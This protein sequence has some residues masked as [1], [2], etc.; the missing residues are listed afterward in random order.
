M[1]KRKLRQKRAATDV[2]GFIQDLKFLDRKLLLLFIALLLLS[3]VAAQTYALRGSVFGST[4]NIFEKP[5][6]LSSPVALSQPALYP[7][8][9]T[10]EPPPSV[11]AQSA[12]VIDVPSQV[13]L[14]EK[15]QDVR[16]PA[17]STTKIM[18]A[19]VGTDYFTP[20]TVLPVPAFS[21]EAAKMG[22]VEGEQITFEN[23]LYGL[24]LS[25]GNDAAETIARQSVLG[26]EGFI[27]KM[28]EKARVLHLGNTYYGD[29]TGLS[30]ANHTSALDLARLA[31]HVLKNPTLSEIVAT[32]SKVVSDISGEHVHELENLNKLLGEVEGVMGLKT[33]FTQEAGQVLVT[34]AARNGHTIVTVVL[35]SE[36]RFLDSRNLLEWAFANFTFVPAILP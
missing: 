6:I 10:N 24:L 9:V 11:S 26:R 25:S 21:I 1:K 8:K 20:D 3:F 29:P 36:D 19:L 14:Y 2:K 12:L 23:L 27:A 7:K 28:N 33:G 16:F 30:V 31:S 15:N 17:A 4:T 13:V 35:K 18:T 22:L 32:K 5:T 34:A